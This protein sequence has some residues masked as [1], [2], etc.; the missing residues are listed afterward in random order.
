[1]DLAAFQVSLE[2][3]HRGN[4]VVEDDEEVDK[5]VEELTSAIQEATAVSAPKHR[6]CADSQLALPLVF[7]IK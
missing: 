6:S 7:R 3:R 5:C 4:P 2:D 1:M